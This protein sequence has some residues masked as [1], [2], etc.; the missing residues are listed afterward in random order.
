MKT[1]LLQLPIIYAGLVLVWGSTWIAIKVSVGDTPFLMAAIRFFIA[2]MLLAFYQRMRGK[3]ILPPPGYSRPIIT[4]GVGNFF[5]G[6]G[7]TYWG[8]Q[9]VNSNITSILWATLPVMVSLF[10]HFMLKDEKLNGSKVFSLCGALIGSYLIF[11]IQGQDFD[12]QSSLGMAVV[13]I[14]ILG[15]AYSN[16]LYKRDASHLDPVSSNTLGML[17]GAC[18]LLISGL[19]SEPLTSVEFSTLIW[20]ATLYLAIFGSAIG[21]SVY[22]WLLSQVSVV[23]MSYITFL[24]PILA[25]IWGWVILN[26]GLSLRSFIGAVIILGSVSLPE[27]FPLKRGRVSG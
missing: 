14:S 20:G 27:L 17:I 24:I 13:L 9:F 3:A 19:I 6:Y 15:A 23:K 25:S 11:N 5:I 21:F 2:S 16:V 4:L 22:F 7:F 8:M 1:K 26:E 10:A 12:L 18:L